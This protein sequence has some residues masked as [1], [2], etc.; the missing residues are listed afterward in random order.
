MV[1]IVDFNA[2]RSSW[3]L[4]EVDSIYLDG[5]KGLVRTVYVKTKSSVLTRPVTKLLLVLEGE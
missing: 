4:G 2:P 1:L 5:G 3:P